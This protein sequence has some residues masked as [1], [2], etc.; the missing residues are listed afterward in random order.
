MSWRG[1]G[2]PRE[3]R[4]Q[5]AAAH[6]PDAGPEEHLPGCGRAPSCAGCAAGA[7][8]SPSRTAAAEACPCSR[9]WRCCFACQ[10]W[11]LKSASYA[12]SAC[13]AGS[14]HVHVAAYEQ[15]KRRA[16]GILC[17]ACHPHIKGLTRK[18]IFFCDFEHVQR[19][20]CCKQAWRRHG[21]QARDIDTFGAE[22]QDAAHLAGD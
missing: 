9:C 4:A 3:G 21:L 8:G 7:G 22:L 2:S 16:L 17:I 20:C 6:A 5:R 1:L 14:N 12:I 11:A 18:C 19:G 10:A 15:S 13:S